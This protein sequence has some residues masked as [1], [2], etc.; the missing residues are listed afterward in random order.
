MYIQLA[1]DVW[2]LLVRVNGTPS[3]LWLLCALLRSQT[4]IFRTKKNFC[5]MSLC[6]LN[7]SIVISAHSAQNYIL[8]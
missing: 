4:G 1:L 7:A 8:K 5:E 2:R 6:S 3:L